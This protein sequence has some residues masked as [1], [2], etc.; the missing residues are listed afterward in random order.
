[1]LVVPAQAGTQLLPFDLLVLKSQ[2]FRSPFERAG[3]FLFSSEEKV[4][5]ETPPQNIAPY[6]HPALRVRVSGRV[7]LT[8]T[9]VCRQ[10]NARDPSRAP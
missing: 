4:T 5:K 8:C 3:Y 1:L 10:R 6:A 9:S 2:G 7:P